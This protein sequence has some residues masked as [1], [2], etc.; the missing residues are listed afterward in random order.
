MHKNDDDMTRYWSM[1]YE[2]NVYEKCVPWTRT[3]QPTVKVTNY[4][5]LRLY[6][7]CQTF[8]G[9]VLDTY[10]NVLFPAVVRQL[11]ER[12]NC[13]SVNKRTTQSTIDSYWNLPVRLLDSHHNVLD[14]CQNAL[15][16][17]H[18]MLK[19]FT[20]SHKR[21]ITSVLYIQWP[22][23][24]YWNVLKDNYQNVLGH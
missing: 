1:K 17:N 12:R 19:T 4:D 18:K 13:N 20:G 8:P 23:I 2:V 5:P 10:Q 14:S 6:C 24:I 15:V 16:S 22:V 11:P 21:V 3:N 9:T 7:T